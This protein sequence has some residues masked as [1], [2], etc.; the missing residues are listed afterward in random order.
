[1]R[2][3][4]ILAGAGS[5]LLALPLLAANRPA[6]DKL[7][8]GTKAPEID[9]PTWFNH[10]G[11]PLALANLRG[12]PVLID[13]W[14]TWC[15][16]CRA[17]WPHLQEIHDEFADDGLVVLAI[18]D[19]DP[20]KVAEFLDTNGYTVATGAGSNSH[21]PYGGS[22][23]PDC[24]LIGPDG[25]ILWR[26]HP[27]SLSTGTIKEA[28]KGVKKPAGSGYMSLTSSVPA[29]G[30][31]EKPVGLAAEGKLAKA[32]DAARA[33]AADPKSDADT[34]DAANALV[35]DVEE[36]AAILNAQAQTF[37]DRLDLVRAVEVYGSVAKELANEE[38]GKVAKER[39]DAIAKDE[40]LQ[41]EL[42]A[43]ETFAKLKHSTEKLSTAKRRKKF[44]EFADDFQGTKAADRAKAWI[45]AN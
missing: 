18:S 17:A 45:A 21:G 22:G 38:A 42:K 13:F 2:S 9:V 14:A 4:T 7:G 24:V 11:Q 37:A 40:H 19:E 35:K 10:V 32:L 15:A 3:T 23:I 1:M 31:L 33:L 8:P 34:K 27:M 5:L 25:S 12:R 43:A 20:D 29:T 30:A 6:G 26:D 16:P 28:L 41:N 39:L 36:Y 44:E